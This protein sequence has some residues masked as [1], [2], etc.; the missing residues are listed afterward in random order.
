M[1]VVGPVPL[2]TACELRQVNC[3]RSMKML[4]S[5][6]RMLVSRGSLLG[7]QSA[8][9]PTFPLV[10]FSWSLFPKSPFP[11]LQTRGITPYISSA[12]GCSAKG[13]VLGCR[14]SV[15]GEPF[16]SRF[17]MLKCRVAYCIQVTQVMGRFCELR[18]DLLQDL[19]S[20]GKCLSQGCGLVCLSE[21]GN[22]VRLFPEGKSDLGEGRHRDA[23]CQWRY[24]ADIPHELSETHLQLQ[25]L[26]KN[27]PEALV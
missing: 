7:S 4:P 27:I 13:Q 19:N 15:E 14:V 11:S 18:T 9:S 8:F 6:A 2:A 23:H 10:M 16:Q 25:G 24:M 12:P 17:H 22:E 20:E 1:S 5:A 21:L 3:W 26:N